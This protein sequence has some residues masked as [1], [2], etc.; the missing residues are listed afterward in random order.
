MLVVEPGVD[1]VVEPVVESVVDSLD[2]HDVPR[3]CGIPDGCG[4]LIAGVAPA[5]VVTL[6]G[7]ASEPELVLR[8]ESAP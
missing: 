7:I 4:A 5:G 2:D 1:S 8:V 3:F 6:V